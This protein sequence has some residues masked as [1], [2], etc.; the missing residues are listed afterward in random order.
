MLNILLAAAEYKGTREVMLQ[1]MIDAIYC[2][3]C[4]KL[5]MDFSLLSLFDASSS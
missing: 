4:L 1:T 3:C 2:V 5:V